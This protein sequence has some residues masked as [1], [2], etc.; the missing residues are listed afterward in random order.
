MTTCTR[1]GGTGFLNIH[2][3]P[4]VKSDI[5]LESP[6]QTLQWIE[7]NDDH[8]VSV[9]DCC[10]NGEEWYGT[11]GEHYGPDDPPGERGPYAYNGGLCECH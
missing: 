2:Q 1:C 8:D 3:I 9:C 10:G 5:V 11:P 6:E 7:E 4:D